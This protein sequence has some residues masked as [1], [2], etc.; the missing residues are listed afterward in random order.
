MAS[1]TCQT[2]IIL[3]VGGVIWNACNEVLLIRR[4][5]PPRQNEWSLPGGKVEAG[6]SL[7]AA[8]VRE[9]REETGLAIEIIGL[10]DVAELILDEAAGAAGRHHVL[11]DFCA[12]ALSGEAV[13]ASDA[14]EARWFTPAELDALPLWSETRRV[15]SESA[16]LLKKP[17]HPE[18]AKGC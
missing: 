17:P 12:R 6:E 1:E 2:G 7:H 4:L 14:G 11:V 10:V 18:R 3:G 8:L 9:V 13:A 5:N 16:N 15:I